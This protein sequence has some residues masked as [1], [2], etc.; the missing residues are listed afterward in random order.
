MTIPRIGTR[1]RGSK[2]GRPIMVVLDLL[3]RRAA[4]RMLWELRNEPLNFRALQQACDTNPSLLNTRLKELRAAGLVEHGEGGYQLT[5]EGRELSVALRPLSVW[6]A[7][8]GGADAHPGSLSAK[9]QGSAP[10]K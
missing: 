10:S 4:L 6:A 2:S 9:V 8:W 3:G 1:V 5:S 7:A